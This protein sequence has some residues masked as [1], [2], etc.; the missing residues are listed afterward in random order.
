M[1]DQTTI[2]P[3][4]ITSMSDDQLREH[5]LYAAISAAQFLADGLDTHARERATLYAALDAEARKRHG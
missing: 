4:H 2:T 5:R 3:A 1:Q